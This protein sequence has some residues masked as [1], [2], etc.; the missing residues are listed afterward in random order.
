[1]RWGQYRR[2]LGHVRNHLDRLQLS[3]F[4]PLSDFLHLGF[5]DHN[6]PCRFQL[7]L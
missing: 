7:F 5:P 1:M 3:V 6:Q 4:L 2:I